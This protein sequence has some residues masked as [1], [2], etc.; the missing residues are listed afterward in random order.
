MNISQ[1][2]NDSKKRIA[3]AGIIFIIVVGISLAVWYLATHHATNTTP[4]QPERGPTAEEQKKS[5]KSDASQKQ[6]FLDNEVKEKDNKTTTEQKPDVPSSSDITLTARTDGNF[7]VVTT[8]LATVA[9]GTCTLTITGGATPVT[10]QANIIYSPEY[11]SCAGFSVK[12]DVVNAT[13]WN[14]TLT[15]N[16]DSSKI[17]KSIQ[18]T[19]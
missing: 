12:K 1:P 15:V 18:F 9:S 11:S 5:D 7:V 17:E 2:H 6:E 16:T 4:H 13:S 3:L 8:K 19:P 14:I 10:Q